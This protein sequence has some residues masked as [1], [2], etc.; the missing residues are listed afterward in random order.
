MTTPLLQRAAP[1]VSGSSTTFSFPEV[2]QGAEAL[3]SVSVPGSSAFQSWTVALGSGPVGSMVGNNPFGPL[4]V[5][6]GQRVTVTGPPTT[7]QAVLT[8]VTGPVGTIGGSPLLASGGTSGSVSV[9]TFV[10]PA[11]PAA[12]NDIIYMVPSGTPLRLVSFRATLTTSS[13]S[14]RRYPYLWQVVVNDTT[15]TEETL[16]TG[17]SIGVSQTVVI[18]A[19]PGGGP[20]TRSTPRRPA[21]GTFSTTV[22]TLYTAPAGG[23]FSGGSLFLYNPGSATLTAF[24]QVAGVTVAAVSIGATLSAMVPIPELQAGDVLT[25]N[26]STGSVDYTLSGQENA[27]DRRVSSFS[28]LLLPPGSTIQTATGGLQS[29]DTWSDINLAFVQS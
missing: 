4:Y 9:P 13:Q 24:V 22:T 29:G 19:V 23:W 12:G 27:D 15:P 1:A 20:G 6:P 2:P 10:A 11:N 18:D 26:T 8:G 21:T 7:T 5:G 16:L 3:V 17:D 28:G 14:G 25:A